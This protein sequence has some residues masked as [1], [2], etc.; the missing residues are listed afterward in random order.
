M[1]VP[2]FRHLL[3][4]AAPLTMR[5]QRARTTTALAVLAPRKIAAK[6]VRLVNGVMR[7]AVLARH[8]TPA[9]PQADTGNGVETRSADTRPSGARVGY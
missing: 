2:I 1:Q 5:A 9:L 4:L 6:L 3:A 7:A 8:V